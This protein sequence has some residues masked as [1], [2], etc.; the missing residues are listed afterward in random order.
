MT[1]LA[2][3]TVTAAEEAPDRPAVRLDDLTLSY[4]AL[5]GAVARAAALLRAEG[6]GVGAAQPPRAQAK[7]AAYKY[8][9][10]VWLT[11]ELPKG[12]TEKI[13]KREIT[14]PSP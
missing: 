13:L 3:L 12:P 8:P 6:V 14:R 2:L 4:A 9:R 10:V 11:D 7:V 1:N 5:D